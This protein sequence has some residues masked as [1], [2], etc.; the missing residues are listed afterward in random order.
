[1]HYMIGLLARE[2]EKLAQDNGF[3]RDEYRLIQRW[4]EME[5]LQFVEGDTL[6][7]VFQ[8]NG[9]KPVHARIR[10]DLRRAILK[11]GFRPPSLRFPD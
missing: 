5:G 8:A 11:S 7:Y 1:M 4:G 3:G 2:A 6:T 10:S 9:R